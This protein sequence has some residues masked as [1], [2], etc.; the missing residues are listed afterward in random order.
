MRLPKKPQ[1]LKDLPEFCNSVIE[2]LRM[3]RI[4]NVV[5]GRVSQTTSGT[6][7]TINQQ[8]SPKYEKSLRVPFLTFIRESIDEEDQ[9]VFL[10]SMVDGYIITRSNTGDAAGLLVV[11]NIPTDLE[12]AEGDK[13]YCEIEE[14][15][16]GNAVSATIGKDVEWPESVAPELE[17]G[18]SDGSGGY[19][20]IR[21]AE[22][23]APEGQRLKTSQLLTGHIDHFQPGFIDNLNSEYPTGDG[24]NFLA[25]YDNG[26]WQL[27]S[28]IKGKGQLLINEEAD[29]VEIRGNQKKA[30]ITYQ[31][32]DNSPVDLVE[33]VDGLIIDGADEEDP[34]EPVEA[35]VFNIPIPEGG[36]G[37]AGIHFSFKTVKAGIVEEDQT[38]DVTGGKVIDVTADA[39]TSIASASLIAD[40][41]DS[42]WVRIERN[43]STREIT[44]AELIVRGDAFIEPSDEQY[45]YVL[46]ATIKDDGGVLQNQ[47]GDIAIQEE[48]LVSNGAFQ[49]SV[50]HM[51]H[52]NNYEPPV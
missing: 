34:E 30:K 41:T 25:R 21:I 49:L 10:L 45:Q 13:I 24:G 42:I 31:I 51:A 20:Y 5:G 37:G 8:V 9:Q 6:T 40:P 50:Y 17:G 3:V 4:G 47:F 33:F 19:R 22:V 29:E 43:T 26:A 1:S 28:V 7:I 12:V 11:D 2:Y 39:F 18:D 52:L 35:Q 14:D 38:Y 36:E 23:I 16:L 15:G 44:D 32:G 48:L 27:R 46:I